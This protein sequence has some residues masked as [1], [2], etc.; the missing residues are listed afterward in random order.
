MDYLRDAVE[1]FRSGNPRAAE[2]ACEMRLADS[3][4]D[5]D[6]LALLAEIHV[7]T[8]N[9]ERAAAT[10][11]R[12]VHYRPRDAAAHRRLAGALTG[13]GRAHEAAAALRVA[14]QIE[15]SSARA[16]NNL[17]QALM[18]VGNLPEAIQSFRMALTLDATYAVAHCNLALAHAASDN[19]EQALQCYEYALRHAPHLVD[20]WMGRGVL[21]AR[22][23][24]CEPAL[25]CFDAAL[26]LRPGDAN[27]LT[28]R[29]LVLLSLE[30]PMECL[31]SAA[32]AIRVDARLA[33]AHNVKAGALRRL[34]R[35]AEALRSL[36]RA[37]EL[38]PTH[39]EAWRNRSTVLHEMGQVD[40]AMAACQKALELDPSD[41]QTRTRLLARMIPQV[42]LC[43][44]DVVSARGA[45]EMRLR[46]FESWLSLRDLDER[47]AL[48][49]AQQQFFYLSYQEA[50][51]RDLL[52]RYR[53]ASAA[54]LAG[55]TRLSEPGV[56]MTAVPALGTPRRFRLG[57]VSAHL[58]DHSVFNALVQGWL[59]CLDRTQFEITLFGLGPKQDALTSAAA[60]SVDHVEMESR[61]TESW[62]R[63]IRARKL[64]ALIYPE[65]GMNETTLALAALRLAPRQFAAWG[66]PETSGLPTIDGFLSAELFEPENAQDH[67]TERLIRLPNLGVHCRP[68]GVEA[69]RVDRQSLHIDGDA[70]LFICP[71]VPFKYRPEDDRVFVEIARRLGSCTFIFFEHALAE[72]S[73][74]LHSR[75]ATAFAKAELNAAR[76]VRW[77]PWQAR[78][79]FFGLLRQAD[80]YLDTLGFS[81]FNTM[82]QAIECD[83]PC[84][85]HEGKFMRGRLGTGILKRLGMPEWIAHDQEH[86]IDLA[87]TLGANAGIRAEVRTNIRRVKSIAY[88]DVEAV[89]ALARVLLESATH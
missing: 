26:T 2:R 9:H 56:E 57:I 22:L 1:L 39:L 35:H 52:Q 73:R 70:P 12:L 79:G 31:D 14:I 17:G 46:E 82:I 53:S 21:L 77:I 11:A 5:V 84:I 19:V 30:R 60:T 72:L 16:H 34:G 47:D 75:I 40:A 63:V 50:S 89:E 13:L 55:F 69:A 27:T 65:I 67:Y 10:L 20:A 33:E 83:L 38:E 23:H 76:Y 25:Q 43:V 44:D 71:G 64:D 3:R 59:T 41:I 81:G 51:N 54:R 85:T 78:P 6:A 29:A 42:P 66:H 88:G 45:F 7:A 49:A 48:T 32:A 68:Y 36:E 8:G 86:Y 80:V 58:Y 37:L 4:D 61:S 28:K 18:Q 87:V 74:K 15:P 24:R 62:V